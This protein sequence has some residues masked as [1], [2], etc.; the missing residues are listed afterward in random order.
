MY[1]QYR[2]IDAP[3]TPLRMILSQRGIGKTFGAVL[4]CVKNYLKNGEK[5]IYVVETLE[6]V[7]ILQQR[8]GEKFFN[9]IF[10][11]LN[12]NYSKNNEKILNS[13][14][15]CM[16]EENN[17]TNKGVASIYGG[18][19]IINNNTAGY[20][21]SFNDFAKLKRNNFNDVKYVI[22]DEFIPETININYNKN[23]M[24][25]SS[26]IQSIARTRDC[27]FYLLANP[28][29][30][31]DPLL[32]K[33][34][35]DNIKP[36]DFRIIKDKFGA[37]LTVH[38]VDRSEMQEFTEKAEKSV[39]GRVATMLKE[40]SL[41]KG[42]FNDS[43]DDRML[44]P[45]KLDNYVYAYTL[46]GEDKVRVNRADNG[47]YYITQNYGSGKKYCVDKSYT[48]PKIVYMKELKDI[49]IRI[50]QS[51]RCRFDMSSTWIIFKDILNLN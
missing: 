48:E 10:D 30:R 5:F 18:A 42:I 45:V 6:M 31:H 33:F 3:N 20:I 26:L 32:L 44:M 25:I 35:L 2:R 24:K 23:S 22:I 9:A 8:K 16:V 4:K 21:I 29:R 47:D 38:Y 43:F 34:G 19:I 12:K 40:D 41:E 27:I 28:I 37:L 15:G 7:R 39:A 11:Y 49:L 17:E 50:Y 51:D 13:L 1:Y 36:K 46:C 14:N